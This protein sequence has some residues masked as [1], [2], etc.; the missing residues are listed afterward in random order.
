MQCFT[1]SASAGSVQVTS[2]SLEKLRVSSAKQETANF[3]SWTKNDPIDWTPDLT[4]QFSEFCTTPQL[5]TSCKGLTGPFRLTR[6]PMSQFMIYFLGYLMWL[7][8]LT[9]VCRSSLS[10][11][12]FAFA[13]GRYEMASSWN[14][15][16]TTLTED[17]HWTYDFTKSKVLLRWIQFY[18][19]HRFSGAFIFGPNIGKDLAEWKNKWFKRRK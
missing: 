14:V 19:L 6:H 12:P 13:F 2:E 16:S 17:S 11:V 8:P 10:K 18:H 15:I 4:R 1:S 5:V 9:L 3:C 7:L